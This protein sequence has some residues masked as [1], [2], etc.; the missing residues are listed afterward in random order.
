MANFTF[1]NNSNAPISIGEY[2]TSG[3]F[4]GQGQ[5]GAGS[6]YPVST[7]TGYIWTVSNA[8]GACLGGFKV[9][10]SGSVTVVS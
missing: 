6:S 9:Q 3:G 8:N 1:I 2:T 4:V 7:Y 5:V 10:G